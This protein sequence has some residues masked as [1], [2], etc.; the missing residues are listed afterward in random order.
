MLM[1][2][3]NCAQTIYL[4]ACISKTRSFTPSRGLDPGEGTIAVDD[5]IERKA[6]LRHL[7]K[8]EVIHSDDARVAASALAQPNNGVRDPMH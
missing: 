7:V 8:V 4:L 2:V 3:V 5:V 6:S 1:N